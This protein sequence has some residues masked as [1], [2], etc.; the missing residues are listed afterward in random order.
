[1]NNYRRNWMILLAVLIVFIGVVA[2]FMAVHNDFQSVT[3]FYQT[4]FQIAGESCGGSCT[5]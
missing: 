5:I 3:T 2:L 1:M 4:G